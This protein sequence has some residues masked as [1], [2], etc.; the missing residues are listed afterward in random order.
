MG[1]PLHLVITQARAV[2]DDGNG[3]APVGDGGEDVDLGERAVH[4]VSVAGVAAPP[5]RVG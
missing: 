4:A 1:E 3:V 5:C 2:E